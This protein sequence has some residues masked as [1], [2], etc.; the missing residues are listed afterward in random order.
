MDYLRERGYTSCYL[1]TEKELTAA[2]ALYKR[3]GFVLAEEK[4]S[5]IFG[6]PGIE[7][8]YELKIAPEPDRPARSRP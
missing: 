1:L 5:A 4:E 8:R 2:A 7:C 3:A 6:R